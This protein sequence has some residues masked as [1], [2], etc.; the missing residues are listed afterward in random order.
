VPYANFGN[1]QSLNLYAY[2]EN[3]PTTLGDPDGHQGNQSHADAAWTGSCS[4]TKN[5]CKAAWSTD[6]AAKAANQSAQNTWTTT[7]QGQNTLSYSFT[8]NTTTEHADGSITSVSTTTTATFS[9]AKGHE[10]QFLGAAT[11]TTT[12]Q[13]PANMADPVRNTTTR[14]QAISYAQAAGAM[15]ANRM[16][17]GGAAALPSFAAHFGNAVANDA[18]S[19][20]MKYVFAAGEI[21]LIFTPLPAGLAAIEGIH[22]VKASVDAG[23]AAGDLTW[24][25]LQK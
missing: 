17:E 2:V 23:V 3:N 16:A 7:T 24:E 8:K 21:G 15:G 20:P 22:E 10:G 19:H 18:R 5:D 1:P 6:A 13:I 4:T 11:E 12:S 9:T 25:L 14:Q